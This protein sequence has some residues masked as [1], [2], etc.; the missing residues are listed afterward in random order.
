[1]TAEEFI[2]QQYEMY[3][4][5]K[6][7]SFLDKYVYD[8]SDRHL[9]TNK[10]TSEIPYDYNKHCYYL[11][12]DKNKIFFLL[13]VYKNRIFY[14]K[15][16]AEYINNAFRNGLISTLCEILEFDENGKVEEG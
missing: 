8:C 7:S 11:V 3:N 6:L 5:H 14:H 9:Y 2:T 13:E 15:E 16:F 12:G 1:M 10:E 4:S